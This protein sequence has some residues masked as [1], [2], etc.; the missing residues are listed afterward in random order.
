M[1]FAHCLHIV[2]VI[3]K[4][5]DIFM[6]DFFSGGGGQEEGLLGKI[7]PWRMFPWGK[8]HFYEGGARFPSII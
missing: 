2:L 8:G 4:F 1:N 5:T 6:K 7:F 3:M